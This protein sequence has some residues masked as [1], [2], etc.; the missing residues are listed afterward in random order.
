MFSV[1]VNEA[2]NIRTTDTDICGEINKRFIDTDGTDAI[3]QDM[4]FSKGE[5]S[6]WTCEDH[7]LDPSSITD[8]VHTQDPSINTDN[9]ALPFAS[10]PRP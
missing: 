7:I 4:E 3:R 9:V 6:L 2:L 5:W 10:H 8:K 1:S